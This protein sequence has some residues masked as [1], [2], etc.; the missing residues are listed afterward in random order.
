MANAWI[1]APLP[2]VDVIA[3]ADAGHGGL[4]V[5]NDYAGVIW[6]APLN[7]GGVVQLILDIGQ[8]ASFDTVALFG[9]RFTGSAGAL[10]FYTRSAPGEAWTLVAPAQPVFAGAQSLADGRGVSLFAADQPIVN[11]Q[12]LI[13]VYS[14]TAGFVEVARAVIGARI[15]LERNFSFGASIGVKDL[16]SLEFSRRGVLLRA[17]GAKLRTV[18]LTFSSAHKTEVEA[19]TQPLFERIGNTECVALVT[20]PAPDVLR[21]RRCYFGPLVGDLSQTWRRADAWEA[22]VNLVSAF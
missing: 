22:K 18:A 8:M 15:V 6:R 1:I 2:I 4:N 16:G 19:M 3:A 9:V 12:V 11:R 17:S 20:D 13:E 10:N 5:A 21:Q 7:P 14:A